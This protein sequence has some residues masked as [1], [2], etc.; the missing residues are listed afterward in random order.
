MREEEK[1]II[2]EDNYERAVEKLKILKKY[3]ED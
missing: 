1:Y 2:I 3:L